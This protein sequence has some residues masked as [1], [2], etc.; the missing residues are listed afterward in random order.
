MLNTYAPLKRCN[1]GNLQLK[2]IDDRQVDD[3]AKDGGKLDRYNVA[4][5]LASQVAHQADRSVHDVHRVRQN[6]PR[7]E[8]E[9]LATEA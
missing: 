3:Y 4:Q 5:V 8:K 7:E 6:R 2:G 9:D 1:P